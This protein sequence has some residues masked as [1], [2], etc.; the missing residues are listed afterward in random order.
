MRSD[1]KAVG[2]HVFAGGFS[3]G[4]QRACNLTCQL[5]THGF[6]RETMEKIVKVPFINDKQA[7]WPDIRDAQFCF[8]NPRCT[9]F[10]TITSGYGEDVHGPAAKCTVDIHQLCNYAAGRFDVIVWESVQQAYSVGKPLL[11]YLVKEVFEPKHYRVAHVFINAASFGNAQQRKRYFFVA[12]RDDR[13]FNIV[14]PDISS[15]YNTVHGAIGHLKDRETHAGKLYGDHEYDFDTYVDLSD[16][17]WAVVPHLPNGWCMNIFAK[18]RTHLLPPRMMTTWKLRAS[19]MPF[20]MHCIGRINY[21]R[22]S[23]TIH[24]SACRMI[25][26]ELDRPLTVGELATIMGWPD[27]PVGSAPSAQIAKGVVPDV[28]QWL[29]EQAILCIDNHWGKDDFES[30]F[31]DNTGEWEGRD[32]ESERPLE[33]VFNMTKFVGK[34]YRHYDDSAIRRV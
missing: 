24:S 4:V 1:I 25:H 33:K 12:Y 13:N 2:I 10:S 34:D 8:G 19:D 14:P 28:G 27:I 22:P 5:E 15:Y 20:S 23:P 11:D 3:M 31:N 6:G 9:G 30:S 29:A 7:N 21:N 16:D 26:P 32:C 17:E 18:Y